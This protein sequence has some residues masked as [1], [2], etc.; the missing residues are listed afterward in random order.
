MFTFSPSRGRQ[1]SE[2][3]GSLVYRMSSRKA[4]TT[5]RNPAPPQKKINNQP[6]PT[7]LF[8]LITMDQKGQVELNI[9]SGIWGVRDRDREKQ[10]QIWTEPDIYTDRQIQRERQREIQIGF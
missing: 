3:E 2:F 7:L 4:K 5:Q 9:K 8:H 6:Q 1:I 10:R